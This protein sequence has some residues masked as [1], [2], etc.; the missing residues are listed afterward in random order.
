MVPLTAGLECVTAMHVGGVVLH[1]VGL[2]IA[3]LRK[4]IGKSVATQA[5]ADAVASGA[6]VDA[7]NVA[8]RPLTARFSA[9]IDVAARVAVLRLVNEVAGPIADPVSTDLVS[10][11]RNVHPCAI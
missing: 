11:G 7:R 6:G 5:S 8:A 4:I 9:E 3:I 10:D 2:H 1:L